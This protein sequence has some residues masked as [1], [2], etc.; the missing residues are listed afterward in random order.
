MSELK[1]IRIGGGQGFWGDSPDA[2]IDM[3]K[4][5][6]IDYISCDYL[7]E[8][9]M[10]I[11]QRQK[12]KDKNK[13]YAKDFLFLFKSILKDCKEKNI[14]IL[15]NAGGVNV[16]S[17]AYELKSIAKDNGI[18]NYKIGYITGDNLTDKM[19]GYISDGYKFKNMDTN[20]DITEIKD[21]ILNANVYFG[22][23]PFLKLLSENANVIVSGRA[24]DSTLFLSPLM[25]EF[26]W[27]DD[28]LDNIARGIA[29]G[30]MLECGGQASGGNYQ[31]DWKNVPNIDNLGFPIAE[32][33]NDKIVFTKTK[34][35]GGLIT[36]ESLKEQFLYEI[37]DPKNYITPDVT[38]D[39]SK[40]VINEIGKNR[41][42]LSNIRG[43][44]RPEKLK[45]SIG[46]NAGYKVETYLNFA[47]PD[48]Y[49]K[50]KLASEIIMKK[51]KRK[52]LKAKDIRVDFVGLNALHM[53][54]SDMS[55]EVLDKQNE[56]LLRIA[57]RVEEK[58]EA[59]KLIPEISPMQ[60]NG[61]P[62]ASFFG[63][64]A[65]I[66]PVIGLWP[67]LIPRDMVELNTNIM[68]VS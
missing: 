13:G 2:A 66:Q 48:A 22:R 9:T 38:A 42:E 62:G 45:L 29:V 59:Q 15:S 30:H 4:N 52:G 41:V 54:L 26:K 55:K 68:E 37:H 20:Q 61:P 19:Q 56:V 23:E 14:K 21:K 67:T 5:G 28:D 27:K 18:N 60:L 63:G 49:E 58:E 1:T 3:V 12:N 65:K 10:S 16:E 43:R 31:Y 35:S 44:K 34:T 11:L 8:L 53:Q 64:R 17:L 47:W 6:N 39:F 24:A 50:A 36:E 7:A 25:H 51:M 46:Y 32:V 33:S 40:A 57:I